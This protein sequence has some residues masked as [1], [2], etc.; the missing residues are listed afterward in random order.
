MLHKQVSELRG[1]GCPCR[2]GHP[3]IPG[4]TRQCDWSLP[5][6][7]VPGTC[8]RKL[9]IPR[10]QGQVLS[11]RCV[12]GASAELGAEKSLGVCCMIDTCNLQAA[13]CPDSS[14]NTSLTGCPEQVLPIHGQTRPPSRGESGPRAGAGWCHPPQCPPHLHPHPCEL[15]L[16][17]SGGC[18]GPAGASVGRPGSGRSRSA[19]VRVTG[20]RSTATPREAQATRPG[21]SSLLISATLRA[22]QQTVACGPNPARLLFL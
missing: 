14:A 17:C 4:G 20:A 3:F 7:T 6:V 22:S 16:P 12:P 2:P 15:T 8:P 1:S 5:D 11:Q 13:G 19:R 21:R 18:T 9:R 10:E